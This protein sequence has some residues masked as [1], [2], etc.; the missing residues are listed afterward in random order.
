MSRTIAPKKVESAHSVEWVNRSGVSESIT[1]LNLHSIAQPKEIA[2]LLNW[3]AYL[4]TPGWYVKSIDLHTGN[5]RKSGQFKPNEAIH[6]PNQKK[7]QKY[8]SF[9]KGD[10]TEVIL[11]LPDMPARPPRLTRAGE[12]MHRRAQTILTEAAQAKA[13]LAMADLARLTNV[14]LGMIEDFEADVTPRLLTHMAEQLTTCQFLLETGA[15]HIL[16]DQ[17]DAQH[18]DIVVAAQLGEGTGADWAEVHPLMREGFVVAAPK[19]QIEADAGTLEQLCALPLIQY[20]AALYRP[21]DHL[22]PGAP[23]RARPPP[24]RAGQLSRDPR[25]GRAGQRLD[26]SA[27][28]RADARPDALRT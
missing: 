28:P 8:I 4:G 12:I 7:A 9:R 22:A 18:L 25:P 23:R 26:Y 27:A 3:N 6:F 11:L 1:E 2:E 17:L 5:L 21:L 14:R 19:G 13:E 15:S 16:H 24:V 20:D 10:G